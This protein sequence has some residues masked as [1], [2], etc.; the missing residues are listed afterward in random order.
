MSFAKAGLDSNL[1]ELGQFF[2]AQIVIPFVFDQKE[3]SPPVF[4]IQNQLLGAGQGWS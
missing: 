2:M 4:I 1:S 3:V